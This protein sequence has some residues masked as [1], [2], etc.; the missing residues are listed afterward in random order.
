[1]ILTGFEHPLAPCFLCGGSVC[2][3]ATVAC[4]PRNRSTRS[5]IV[6]CHLRLDS[7]LTPS[8]SLPT[9][10][11]PPHCTP[12]TGIRPESLRLPAGGFCAESLFACKTAVFPLFHCMHCGPSSCWLLR[13]PAFKPSGRGVSAPTISPPYRTRHTSC[14]VRPGALRVPPPFPSCSLCQP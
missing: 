14:P 6:K 8:L 9:Y 2:Q 13:V 1:M 10:L 11:L 5:V 4:P 12:S 3:T 7:H